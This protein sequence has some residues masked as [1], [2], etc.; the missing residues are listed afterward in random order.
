MSFVGKVLIVVQVVMS[1]C[2]M[3]FAGAVYVTHENWQ[4]K[5]ADSEEALKAAKSSADQIQANLSQ[6]R[7]E[8][9]KLQKDSTEQIERWKLASQTAEA[10]L[11]D[12][13][14]DYDQLSTDYQRQ[15]SLARVKE[16]EA[17]YRED[18]SEVLRAQNSQLQGS[19]DKVTADLNIEKDK[20][21]NAEVALRQLE[22]R[23]TVLSEKT[24]FLEKVVRKYGLPTDPATIAAK[25]APPPPLDGAIEEVEKGKRGR[26]EFVVISVGEDDGLQIGHEL[27]A[28][29]NRGG[30]TLFLG[31]IRVVASWPDHAACEVIAPGKLGDIEVGDNVTTQL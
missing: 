12:K 16:Q 8:L 9:A 25:S 28:F 31:T 30:E 21:F 24:A 18:E 5:Y 29:R 4:T 17:D 23:Y 26:A 22:G 11:A 13:T 2:F 27:V 3:A 10:A 14:R 15:Q 6:S 7:D 20:V 19:L 1:L